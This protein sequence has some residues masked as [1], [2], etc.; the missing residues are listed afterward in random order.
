MS[1]ILGAPDFGEVSYLPQEKV[2]GKRAPQRITA[3]PFHP[4]ACCVLLSP[5]SISSKRVFSYIPGR[6]WC[7]EDQ[8]CPRRA[9]IRHHRPVHNVVNQPT[10]TAWLKGVLFTLMHASL[11]NGLHHSG[12]KSHQKNKKVPA[13]NIQNDRAKC[14]P[15]LTAPSRPLDNLTRYPRRSMPRNRCPIVL[16][17][18]LMPCAT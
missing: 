1:F 12:K 3:D 4:S 13:R 7:S 15:G 6:R 18:T 17:G 5:H 2:F 14:P 16:S 10:P 8:C 9:T 11:S